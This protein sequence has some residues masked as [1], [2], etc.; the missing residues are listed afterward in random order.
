MGVR[1]RMRPRGCEATVFLLWGSATA[2]LLDGGV[3]R[4]AHE[5]RD[6]WWRVGF[7]R[8]EGLKEARPL[9]SQSY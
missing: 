5:E 7:E 4:G 6:G 9:L 2:G 8:G 1:T 3:M